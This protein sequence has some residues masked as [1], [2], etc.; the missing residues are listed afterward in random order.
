MPSTASGLQRKLSFSRSAG[1]VVAKVSRSLSF[2]RKPP[3]PTSLSPSVAEQQP[4]LA[5]PPHPGRPTTAVQA[6]EG[7]R[8]LAYAHA[9]ALIHVRT[10]E[11]P[12]SDAIH[13]DRPACT[14]QVWA[15]EHEGFMYKRALAHGGFQKRW[16]FIQAGLLCYTAPEDE[17]SAV[18][19]GKLL[20][21]RLAEDEPRRGAGG[22]V[23]SLSF[24]RRK[25]KSGESVVLAFQTDQ[26]LYELRVDSLA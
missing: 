8:A 26:R 20:S 25:R 3:R 5:S 2:S 24:S 13:P 14:R 1:G 9:A 21:S 15:I 4:V 12:R 7:V 10:P 11:S 17:Q 6:S 23:R 18:V 22:R 16:F 19:C